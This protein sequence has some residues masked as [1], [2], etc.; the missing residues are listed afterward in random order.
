METVFGSHK[1]SGD[2]D[3]ADFYD[4]QPWFYF[5]SP[6]LFVTCIREEKGTNIYMPRIQVQWHP[7]KS[8]ELFGHLRF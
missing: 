1:L 2:R 8:L 7:S 4:R 3:A 5:I 6:N